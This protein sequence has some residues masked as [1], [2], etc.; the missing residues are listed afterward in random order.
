MA[1]SSGVAMK[2][3][4]QIMT[5]TDWAMILLTLAIALAAIPWLS[6][7]SKGAKV[8]VQCDDRTCYSGPLKRE[9]VVDLD[10]PLGKT[11]LAI[12]DEGARIV[13]SPCPGKLCIS[14]GQ[15]SYAGA[16]LACIPNRIFVRLESSTEESPYDYL[17]R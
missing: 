1:A 9:K 12:N 3:P 2:L 5:P 17:S 10:G 7:A 15:I 8:I 13:S 6:T 16:F 4:W 14:M 11:R